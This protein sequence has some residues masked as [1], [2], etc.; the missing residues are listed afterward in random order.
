M[1]RSSDDT[2]PHPT[3][4]ASLHALTEWELTEQINLL[5]SHQSRY[6]T[7]LPLFGTSWQRHCNDL[8]RLALADRARVYQ[9]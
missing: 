9:R 4:P 5:R 8:E 2:Y 6:A 1:P 7:I 3:V